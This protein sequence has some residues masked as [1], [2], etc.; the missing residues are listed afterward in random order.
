MAN[1][2]VL[3]G[4]DLK[5]KVDLRCEGFDMDTDDFSVTVRSGSSSATY[6]SDDPAWVQDD[7]T[8]DWYLCLPTTGMK[9]LVTRIATLNVPDEDFESGVRKEVVKKD[10]FTVRKP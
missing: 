4:T 1:E 3:L 7:T 6:D 5:I 9:G 10:L 8:G 2:N